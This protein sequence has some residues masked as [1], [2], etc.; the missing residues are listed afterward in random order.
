MSDM[1]RAGLVRVFPICEKN[2]AGEYKGRAA[3][4]TLSK[5]LFGL[6]GL[7]SWLARERKRSYKRKRVQ[8]APTQEARARAGLALDL[9]RAALEGKTTTQERMAVL[10]EALAGNLAAPPPDA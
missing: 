8:A 2:E 1:V 6:L 5:H 4:R 9:A 3:I 7:G 10:R